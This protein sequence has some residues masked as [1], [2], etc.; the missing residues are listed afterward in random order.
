MDRQSSATGN[1][2]HSL[3]PLALQSE[4]TARSTLLT[5]ARVIAFERL[6]RM[7]LSRRSPAVLKDS[8]MALGIRP[9]STLRLRLG[10]DPMAISSSR[11]QETTGLERSLRKVRFP[12]L[13][14]TARRVTSTD[15]QRKRG[16]MAPS[17]LPWTRAA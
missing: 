12:P 17:G 3:I 14:V 4:S 7:E 16:S 9:Y 11:I 15:Q 1:S 13:Q 5:P 8:A 6:R 2:L 10:S